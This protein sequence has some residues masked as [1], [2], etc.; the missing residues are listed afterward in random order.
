MLEILLTALLS[1][2][3]TLA[4][5]Y[6]AGRRIIAEQVLPLVQA[7]VDRRL[8]ELGEVIETRVRNGVVNAVADVTSP[9]S[10]QKQMVKGQDSLLNALFG[11]SAR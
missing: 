2:G 5:A 11:K 9:E 3:L 1:A 10:L 6:L 7:E 8:A 4:G